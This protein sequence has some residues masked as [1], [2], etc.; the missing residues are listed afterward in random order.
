MLLD[1]IYAKFHFQIKVSAAY[2]ALR[3]VKVKKMQLEVLDNNSDQVVNAVTATVDIFAN[4]KGTNPISSITY[5]RSAG[6]VTPYTLFDC[7]A[8]PDNPTEPLLLTTSA[9]SIGTCQAP[10]DQQRFRLTTEYEV[11]DKPTDAS[12]T[13]QLLKS[14]TTP[15]KFTAVIDGDKKKWGYE[16]TVTI[17]VNPTYLQVLSDYD[18]DNPTFTIN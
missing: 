10:Y 17:T 5:R 11:Y 15:N 13:P 4:N 8:D 18:L 9:Q 14:H 6:S 3:T 16:H 12:V 2:D 1:H 7:E